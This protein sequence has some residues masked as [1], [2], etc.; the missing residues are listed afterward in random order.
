MPHTVLDILPYWPCA[1]ELSAVQ[2]IRC[3]KEAGSSGEEIR[4]E[5]TRIQQRHIRRDVGTAGL[6]VPNEPQQSSGCHL[7]VP[8]SVLMERSELN[9][10]QQEGILATLSIQPSHCLLYSTE[11]C[12]GLK[13]A[14]LGTACNIDLTEWRSEWEQN[15]AKEMKKMS[16]CW[17]LHCTGPMAKWGSIN[18]ARMD[19]WTCH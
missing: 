5:T 6:V 18:L 13:L 8:D 2:H 12:P 4:Q 3:S 1:P 15:P 9:K 11:V 10:W 7:F 17:A 14:T 19:L 16:L